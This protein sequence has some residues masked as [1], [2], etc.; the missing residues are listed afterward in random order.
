MTTANNAREGHLVHV[1]TLVCNDSAHAQRCI[2]ALG[3]YGKP[4][5]HAYNCVSYEYGLKEGSSD[6]VCL[7]ERWRQWEDLDALLRDKVVPAL[8][9]YNALLKR[10]FDPACD[11]TRIQLTEASGEAGPQV[12]EE[13]RAKDQ[14]G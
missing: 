1:V 7:I 6:T 13:S 11:T 4:D 12:V 5:A 14:V 2:E 10:P 8:P 3:Q 9:L